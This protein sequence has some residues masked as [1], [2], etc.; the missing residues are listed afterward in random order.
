MLRANSLLQRQPVAAYYLLIFA[1]S[2]SALLSVA[3][4]A[5][6][7]GTPAAL[8]RLLPLGI[9]AMLLGP[10][11]A[12]PLMAYLTDGRQGLQRLWSRLTYFSAERKWVAIA[13]LTAPLTML[14]ILGVLSQ[15]SRAYL[16]AVISDGDKLPLLIMAL[17]AGSAAGIF[18][19]LGWTGFALP[20]LR[21]RFS[22]LST[23]LFMGFLW[24]AWHY[25]VNFWGSGDA[26]GGYDPALL[27]PSLIWSLA[28]LPAYRV[29]MVWMYEV[30]RSLP[31]AMLMHGM[32]TGGMLLFNPVDKSVHVTY[33]LLLTACFAVVSVFVLV[34]RS[35]KRPRRLPGP[36]SEASRRRSGVTAR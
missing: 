32:L 22:V 3:L 11:I 19:E 28:L 29:L 17:T 7:P 31:L 25:I 30:S 18:E 34:W 5:G 9:G 27:I 4:P 21:K 35:G 13:A 20:E 16:P 10:S 33:S 26:S 1:I 2:W 6:F 14:A 12:G 8:E 23:G 24:G 36:P 15:F